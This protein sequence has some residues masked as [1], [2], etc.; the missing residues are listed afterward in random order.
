MQFATD[1]KANSIPVPAGAACRPG[2]DCNSLCVELQSPNLG[3]CG[4]LLGLEEGT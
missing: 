3:S 2:L 1:C 4:G